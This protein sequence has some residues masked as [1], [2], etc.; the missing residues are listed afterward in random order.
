[1]FIPQRIHRSPFLPARIIL[2]NLVNRK[3][4]DIDSGLE[5]WFEGGSDAAEL[6]P[7][8]AT[9]EGMGFD[10]LSAVLAV[11]A[12]EAVVDVAEH[13]VGEVVSH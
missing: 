4:A 2:W 11:M 9:E 8:D 3:V 12:A 7:G 13:T 5:I 6:I 10:I 1:M